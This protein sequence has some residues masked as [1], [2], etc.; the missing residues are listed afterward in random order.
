MPTHYEILGVSREASLDEIKSAYRKLSLKWHPDRCPSDK[1]DE[2]Q[3]K[4]Q[5][6]GA[7]YETLSDERRRQEYNAELDGVRMGGGQ[8]VDMSDIINMMFGG[9]GMPFGMQ[10]MGEMHFGGGG[11]GIHI[12]HGPGMPGGFQQHIFRQMQKPPPIIKQ[13]DITFEQAY[14]GCT[15]YVNVE[16]WTIRND[17]KIN[18]VESVY[19]SIQ[20]GVDNGEIIILRDCGNTVSNDLKGDIKF[21]I[22]VG[23]SSTFERQGMDLIHK[24]TISLK[25]SLTGF[26]FE[27]THANGRTLCLNNMTNRTIVAPNY[28]KSIPGLGMT[29][30]GNVGNLVVIFDVAF[31]ENLTEEQT[32]KIMEIL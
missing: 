19:V 11:P 7:A 15:L 21:I 5:E 20:P 6:I 13:I 2:A 28:R 26:S 29:R 3:S 31:P 27:I 16:K 22:Q 17:V 23:P 12:F 32:A 9:A 1:K 25:E 18:A 10:G 14:A 30:D 4:F 8:E 24:R